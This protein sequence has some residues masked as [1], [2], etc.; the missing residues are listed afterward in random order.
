MSTE[1]KLWRPPQPEPKPEKAPP[2][3]LSQPELA[4]E[5]RRWTDTAMIVDPATGPS[6]Y[7]LRR[8]KSLLAAYPESLTASH[9]RHNLGTRRLSWLNEV[10][11]RWD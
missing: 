1:H 6:P 2:R 10:K 8:V 3:R 9:V 4:I 11:K 7:A 5:L